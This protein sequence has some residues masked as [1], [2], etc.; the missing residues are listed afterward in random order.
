MKL[1]LKIVDC[2]RS[3]PVMAGNALAPVIDLLLARRRLPAC[4]LPTSN[5]PPNF[6]SSDSTSRVKFP[7]ARSGMANCFGYI[8]PGRDARGETSNENGAAEDRAGEPAAG[9]R[10]GS[11]VITA[12][13]QIILIAASTPFI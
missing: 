7:G 1:N 3:E 6:P 5:L 11:I 2:G 4:R 10:A 12:A 13:K 9:R 8:K